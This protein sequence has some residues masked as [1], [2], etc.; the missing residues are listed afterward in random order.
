MDNLEAYDSIEPVAIIGMA[1]R[2]PRARNLDE[3]WQNLRNGVECITFFTDE[4]L[5]ASGAEPALL[6][7]PRYVR[8][9]TVLEDI[10]MF[11]ASFFG[12]SPREAEIM[13]PQHRFFLECAWETLENAGYD[14]DTYNGRIGVYTGVGI[15]TYLLR[16]LISVPDFINS[17]DNYQIAI[18]NDKDFAPTRVS[19]KLNLK[20]PSVNI[21]TACSSSLVA[22]Q[23]ACQSLLNYQCDMVM[24]GGVTI[25]VP[26]KKGY[27]YQEGGIPSPD[28]HCRAFD[29]KAE[30]TVLS[31][32]AGIVLLK[33]LED[34]LEDGDC[35]H[36]LIR[37]S[38]INNDGSLKAGYTAPGPDGQAE[39]IAEAQAIADVNPETITYIEAHGTGT[40]LG[41]PIE[42]AALTRAFRSDT[43]KKGFCAIGSV[44][45]NIGH[46]DT[47][48]GVAGLIKT[49]LSMK[50]KMILPSLNFEQPN[51]EIDFEN[52]PF[53]VNTELSEWK[54]DGKTPRRAGVSSFGIGGTN[55]HV[56]LEEF[57]RQEVRGEGQEAK[58]ERRGANLFRPF[59]LLVLSAKTDTALDAMTANLAEHLRQHP[60]LNLADAAHTLQ[61]GRKTF[62]HRRILVCKDRE[63]AE[64][65]LSTPDM[66]RILTNVQEPG[67]RPV[68]FMFSGQGAQYV[69]MGKELWQTE[70]TFQK[71]IDRCA[72]ILKLH[73]GLDLRQELYEGEGREPGDGSSPLDSTAMAQP[74]LFVIEYALAKLWMEWGVRP[75]AMIGHSIGEYVAACL[76]GVFSLE[77]AL[78][79]VAAR[80]RIMG[81]L[82]E[83]SMLAV[84]L[85]EKEVTPLLGKELSLAAVNTPSLCV[86]S[87]Q[88][89]AVRALQ[90]QLSRQSVECRLLHTSHAFHSEM[91][92]PVVKL[93][94]EQVRRIRLN[95]PQIPY[96]SNVTGTWITA[97]EATAPS[98]WAKHLRQT[99]RFADGIQELLKEPGH[100]LLEIGPGR[101]LC[102]FAMR[103]PD[104]AVEQVVLSSIRHPK[105]RQ[106]DTAFLLTT[107]GR[108]WL[109]GVHAD[110]SEFYA[111]EK[112]CRIPLPAYP[113]E[114]E[115]YWID[116]PK[117]SVKSSDSA[118]Q[119]SDRKP[120]IADWFYVPSW[121]RSPLPVSSFKLPASISW[122]IFLDDCGLGDQLMKQLET[123]GQEVIAVRIGLE[124]AKLNNS[125]YSFNPRRYSDYNALFSELRERN[126]IP[127][128]IVHLWNVTSADHIKP[129]LEKLDK[130][131]D[132]GFSSLVF[133]ARTLAKQNIADKLQ[134][135][136][137]SNNLHEVVG[138]ETVCPEKATLIGPVR[139]IPQEY[140]NVSCR[141][142]D[143]V[144]PEPG[145][146]QEE[147]LASQLRTELAEKCSAPIIALRGNYR[148]IQIFE[149]IRL[150]AQA[151]ETAIRHL[152]KRGV[153][154]I[155]GGLG[156]IGSELAE[157]LVRAMH[158]KLVLTG[159]TKLP[160]REQWD[161][162]LSSDDSADSVSYNFC[163][164]EVRQKIRLRTDMEKDAN[165]ITQQDEAL[166]GSL[167]VR[168]IK[169]CEGLEE[170]LNKLCSGYIYEYFRLSNINTEKGQIYNRDDLRHKLKIS[171]KFEK[172]YA[173][174]VRV[175][176][177][178]SLISVT[179]EN[180]KFLKDT[181]KVNP[182]AELIREAEKRYP[183]FS[184][185]F[186]LLSHCAN[187]YPEALSGEIEAISVLY[188]DGSSDLLA[189]FA[190]NIAEYG[191]YTLYKTLVGK[192]ISEVL[193]K[194]RHRTVRILEVGS[195]NGTLTEVLIPALT[196][197]KVEYY[198]TDI[199]KSFVVKAEKNAAKKG[200]DFMK[201]GVLDISNDPVS[202]GY[203]KYSFDMII[204]LDVVHATKRI[205]E[206]I[207][208]LMK[209]SVPNGIIALIETVRP[210]R[211]EDM[212]WGLAEGWWYFE[213][214]DI[215]KDSPLLGLE[216]WEDVFQKQGLVNIRTYPRNEEK[217][218]E[219]ECGL[220]IGQRED[221]I[222][223]EDSDRISSEIQKEKLK[224]QSR[225]EK[226]KH[227][228]SLGGEVLAFGADV[229]DP[230]QMRTVIHQAYERF[231]EIN[232][233]IH[234]AGYE[235]GGAIQLATP[236]LIHHELGAR[237]R[238]TLVLGSL[239]RDV[240][241]DFFALCSSLHAITGG[242]GLSGYCGACSFIDAF[243]HFNASEYRAVSVNWERWHG[244]GRA[245]GFEERYRAVTGKDLPGGM[246]PREGVEA[247]CRIVFGSALSQVMVSTLDFQKLAEMQSD[248][249][250]LS[251]LED[252][253][254]TD[255]SKPSH[256]RPDL[257][258][259]YVA[260]SNEIEQSLAE[261]WQNLLGIGQVG[262]HD[263]FFEL[264]GDS[265]LGV[266]VISQLR[267][268]FGKEL[269]P[270]DLFEKP[271]V[272]GL[273]EIIVQKEIEEGDEEEMLRLLEK[274]E[275]MPEEEV[276]KI[277]EP[278]PAPPL[279]SR[280]LPLTPLFNEHIT[281]S[282]DQETYITNFSV[283]QHWVLNE[284]RIM[285]NATLPGTAYLEMARA[286][287]EHHTGTETME[288]R[289]A[290]FLRPLAMGENEEKQVRTILK[291]Q[292]QRFDFSV[293]SQ[294]VSG[295]GKWQEHARGEIAS[296]VSEPPETYDIGEIEAECDERKITVAEEDLKLRS[297]VIAFGP[298][299]N[300][301]NW[302]RLG[303]N[304]GLA[305]LELPET[306]VSDIPS[307]KLH[308]ALLDN[309]VGFLAEK[310]RDDENY[311]P[312]YYKSLKIRGA[313]PRKIYSHIR[314]AGNSPSGKETLKFNITIMDEEG[315]EL[316]EIEEYTL[317]KIGA[318]LAL[319][320]P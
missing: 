13:D 313:V 35:I 126:K 312:L 140:P 234:S 287:F 163:A 198:F 64:T 223:G 46:A 267:D 285:G 232:G 224:I 76:A 112:R 79:L 93:F 251:S 203:D 124:F 187:H 228:E 310:I 212:V 190:K 148:W 109:S 80:G 269:T 36:A 59:Q 123:E 242:F 247:F 264:G 293:I 307:Y 107:L 146:R 85:P 54:T 139:V 278:D 113:F 166:T 181:K 259:A 77:D 217:R 231:G 309:A 90:D 279:S 43:Q 315:K 233:V 265:L 159:R 105:D 244:T 132:T 138:G 210:R 100:I 291:K 81:D 185:M 84:P 162:W 3:F 88:T 175:L 143:I 165:F 161:Q 114:R 86:V 2:F 297:E 5:A 65:A 101:T 34:A 248:P 127:G 55:A 214:E 9:G 60:D 38:A 311:L 205:G 128:A 57:Q 98:Y 230:D 122:L 254:K 179:G 29:A 27:L 97:E 304:Q 299:W 52:S 235:R 238:G 4:E 15:N 153:Y 241:L 92:E 253:G 213:D 121:K 170:T 236:E 47:A 103:H 317:R 196:N 130:I 152:R 180:L 183:E 318:K 286:A 194:N 134:I 106:S 298:R 7:N 142:I 274:V 37:G 158:A 70:P 308:P 255:I 111:Y 99:V 261:I 145:M 62:N 219:T 137:I 135:T 280:P 266:Q 24:A 74:V 49:V 302:I 283:G 68:V 23:F 66:K 33:R 172:F 177:E 250:S 193:A 149:P 237:V 118:L 220:I 42:I 125:E 281:D 147:R 44:K 28:G 314:Y 192:I 167:G 83:G 252:S 91:M 273:A 41:D 40:K 303:E 95:P 168:E 243:A 25:Q 39:V 206:T 110:W 108:L 1:G 120:D 31:S 276:R 186:G 211:W 270:G 256:S 45:T 14:P 157:Y 216:K 82:P 151:S 156:G 245:V 94:T 178:D 305:S 191:R 173:F 215:R 229:S 116:P 200:F 201:F 69:N 221:E 189:N 10:E 48:S 208:H 268:T 131:A 150:K 11:D 204:G 6:N 296:L 184:G 115:R 67:Y 32:G 119:S 155:T 249:L 102:T 78:S 240:Q 239:F 197:Q 87:G 174:F 17:A 301:F 258:I 133:L 117:Q 53:Y 209:I 129:G 300:N 207:R 26:Q 320:E 61:V 284:H 72:E 225:I 319:R 306:Y 257:N 51:P 141:S 18:S 227:L 160:E 164:E 188:P 169:S 288:I 171:P 16:N 89:D 271:T 246:T 19:Y 316:V 20:G 71:E 202:Q 22:V 8:Q 282:Q 226:L 96:I 176:S 144:L 21:N 275:Q 292:G 154:L 218:S 199:G 73:L 30:G 58:G 104:R 294:P 295:D 182:P 262:I 75:R 277:L 260:P 136:V 272:A 263:N 12:F 290:Y 63:D 56:V 50:H 222:I 289:N 195:G